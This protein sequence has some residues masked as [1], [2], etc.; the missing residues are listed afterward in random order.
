MS[1]SD[2]RRYFNS[3]WYYKITQCGFILK[4]IFLLQVLYIPVKL[5]ILVFRVYSWYTRHHN[6]FGTSKFMSK[7]N[8]NI[9]ALNFGDVH[10]P[11]LGFWCPTEVIINCASLIDEQFWN[12][13]IKGSFWNTQCDRHIINVCPPSWKRKPLP[14]S[15]LRFLL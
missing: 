13:S 4:M 15:R 6:G 5:R 1:A 10:I 2:I 8:L 9:S 11:I 14:V 12:F 3:R 7:L